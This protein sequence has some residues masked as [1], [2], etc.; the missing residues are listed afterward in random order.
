MNI[1]ALCAASPETLAH[2]PSQ[3]SLSCPV[4]PPSQ[5]ELHKDV[6]GGGGGAAMRARAARAPKAKSCAT[7]CGTS[8]AA[9][10]LVLHVS[11]KG[12][13]VGGLASGSPRAAA[14]LFSYPP[15]RCGG[16]DLKKGLKGPRARSVGR[17]GTSGKPADLV[18]GAPSG[19]K[20]T[21]LVARLLQAALGGARG[22]WEERHISGAESARGALRCGQRRELRHQ[23]REA[24]GL[25]IAGQGTVN[26]RWLRRHAGRR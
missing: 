21:W 4:A 1:E 25:V 26:G 16:L 15:P 3:M 8:S 11:P 9:P 5:H 23:R 12:R 2:S 24:R 18:A 14:Y 22:G 13:R 10:V 19:G 6:G 17:G 20:G 7:S